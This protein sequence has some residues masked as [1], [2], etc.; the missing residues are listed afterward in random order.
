MTSDYLCSL[1]GYNPLLTSAVCMS[2]CPWWRLHSAWLHP[3]H[4]LCS[5]YDY[6]NLNTSAICI[7][8]NPSRPRQFAWLYALH[9]L[10]SL[11]GYMPFTISA[12][13]MVICPWWRLQYTWLI[14]YIPFMSSTISLVIR[15]WWH[16]RS[17]WLYYLAGLCSMYGFTPFWCPVLSAWLYDLDVWSLHG[18]IPLMISAVFMVICPWWPPDATCVLIWFGWPLQY[19]WLYALRIC[20]DHYTSNKITENMTDKSS[21]VWKD[22]KCSNLLYRFFKLCTC[23]WW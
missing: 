14:G 22:T 4:N 3:L 19:A 9:D 16:M 23:C 1:H 6:M 21:I 15:L 17:A 5:L 8:I 11:H 13:C 12:V 18:N 20:V 10:C 7:V 2:I